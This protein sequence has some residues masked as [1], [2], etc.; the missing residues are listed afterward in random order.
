MKIPPIGLGWRG[1]AGAHRAAGTG[2]RRDQGRRERLGPFSRDGTA[3][4]WRTETAAVLHAAGG[5]SCGRGRPW[6]RAGPRRPR[7]RR[8]RRLP[9]VLRRHA[10]ARG[11]PAAARG[12]SYA[13][14][15]PP[16]SAPDH[17]SSPPLPK[18]SVRTVPLAFSPVL[19]RPETGQALTQVLPKDQ[20]SATSHLPLGEPRSAT[21]PPPLESDAGVGWGRTWT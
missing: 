13:R 1:V 4:W 6:R 21:Q 9:P 7:F 17:A 16:F 19:T 11:A 3:G 10:A 20:F 5:R 8:R 18:R 12:S 14:P 15:S 2:G